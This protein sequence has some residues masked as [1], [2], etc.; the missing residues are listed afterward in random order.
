MFK[1]KYYKVIN[2]TKNTTIAIKVK[3]AN[4]FIGRTI[5]LLNRSSITEEEGLLI[6]PCKS[7]HSIFMRFEFDAVF[8]DKNNQVVH[9]INK[10]PKGKVS[11]F[12]WQ[13]NKVLE[14]APGMIEKTNIEIGDV[15]Y[16]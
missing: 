8:L 3:I 1:T 5:G 9:L 7:I 10:M 15:L 13:S 6:I 14:L 4:N 2:K 12:I 11:S 16:Y